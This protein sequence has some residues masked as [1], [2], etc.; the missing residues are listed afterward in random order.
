M[1]L[2][3]SPAQLDVLAR[4][5]KGATLKEIAFDTR[6]SVATIQQHVFA[7]R[8]KIGARTMPHAVYLAMKHDL[9]RP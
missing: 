4:V 6:R 5:A 1:I 9:L 3:L 2:P 7:A 8:R